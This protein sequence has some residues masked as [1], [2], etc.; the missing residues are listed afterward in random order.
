MAENRD[1]IISFDSLC[2]F[3]EVVSDLRRESYALRILW[4]EKIEP[5]AR[6]R[7]GT[8]DLD[9]L[10]DWHLSLLDQYVGDLLTFFRCL[11]EGRPFGSQDGE[12]SGDG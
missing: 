5:R 12:V 1:Y 6:E 4:H 11:T 2:S 9:S 10:A 3:E 7:F 8:G